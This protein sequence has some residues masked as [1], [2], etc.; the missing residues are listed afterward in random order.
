[1]NSD[2]LWAISCYFNPAGYRRR[3]EN[4]RVFRERLAIPL[5]TVELSFD[6]SFE[7]DSNDAEVV[8]Q[9]QGADVMWQKERLLNIAVTRLPSGCDGIAWL[10]CDIVFGNDDWVDQA[11]QA[12]DKY[13]L[14]HLFQNRHDL[15][16]EFDSTKLTTW[17]APPTSESIIYRHQKK[18]TIP[19]DFFLAN[20]P[21][22]RR[23]TAGLAWASRRNLLEKHGLYDAAILGSGDRA[24]VC[25]ALGEFEYAARALIMNPKR[26]E[27][28]RSWAQPYFADVQGQVGNIAARVFHLWHGEIADRQYE[29]RH[30]RFEQFDFNPFD[31]LAIAP[32]GAWQWRSNKP[33]MHDFIKTYFASR[34][35][36]ADFV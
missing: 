8:V 7:L 9:I 29:S 30:R 35:E 32:S 28:Y 21:L 36:D 18:Q 11:T 13:S 15:R 10:D 3:R 12:L 22:D 16:S 2:Q 34:R 17:D 25:A 24:I 5:V 6:G 31:D 4:Y 33:A 19:E 27:H 14:V 26:I 20:A 23:S 1:M